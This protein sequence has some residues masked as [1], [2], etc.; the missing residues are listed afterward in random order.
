MHRGSCL[1]LYYCNMVEWFW[2][3]SSLIFDDQLQ[4]FDTVSLVIW[5]VKVIPE[6]TYNVSSG[7]LNPTHSLCLSCNEVIERCHV[8]C[9]GYHEVPMEPLVPDK[10][11]QKLITDESASGMWEPGAQMI[12]NTVTTNVTMMTADESAVLVSSAVISIVS[13]LA[14]LFAATLFFCLVSDLCIL[15]IVLNC[16]ICIF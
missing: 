3:D 1:E 15:Y 16:F 6:M 14:S 12:D 7:T 10:P 9:V 13:T 5:P 4:C 8:H 2:W 11:V